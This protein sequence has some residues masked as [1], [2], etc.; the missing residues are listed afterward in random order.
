MFNRISLFLCLLLGAFGHLTATEDSIRV[1]L[2]TC[3]P[4]EEVYSLYGH[5]AI[6]CQRISS[7]S[8]AKEERKERI[9]SE[10]AGEGP[11]EGSEGKA[12]FDDV[13]FNY[14]V[15]DMSKPHFV[16]HFVLG[17]TDYM[18]Q[19]IPW[20]YFVLEY[21]ERGSSITEQ[22][23]NLTTAEAERLTKRLVENCRPENCKYRY[24]FL[25]RNCTTMVRDMVEEVVTPAYIL[26]PDTLPH[27]TARE[28]LH[29]YTC[30]HPWAEV[31]NDLLLGAEVDTIMSERAAMFI[32][33]NLSTCFDGA[34]ILNPDGDRRPLVRSKAML[35]QAKPKPQA[36]QASGGDWQQ[37]LTSLVGA[38]P[39]ESALL[40]FALLCIAIL[41]LER[42]LRRIIWPFD[43]LILLL[44]GAAGL[45]LT[46]MFFFSEHP[47]VGSNWQIWPLCPLALLGIPIV[48]KSPGGRGKT[49][50]YAAYFVVLA[51]FL[52]FSP[53]IPQEFAKIT[54]P[55]ALCMLTRP[56]SYHI[57]GNRKPVKK[58]P[59][60]K[61][62]R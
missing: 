60:K 32:P 9:G 26:Y 18:V 20:E 11:T 46:F 40:A 22:E 33:Q 49:F 19:A 13:V 17:Q 34:F 12:S 48:M 55:L 61:S 15:F 53:W 57:A 8:P 44:Q 41:L 43:V 29:G 28:I 23:L 59:H 30:L 51:L 21:E 25:Y 58:Q 5:T 54:V 31:G 42:W 35:L 27:L 10:E 45:L 7:A 52:L 1:T 36:L 6:R 14:G 16:W 37:K 39:V 4:G 62:S 38:R 3:S 2:L 24:N 56:L 47:G 50:W